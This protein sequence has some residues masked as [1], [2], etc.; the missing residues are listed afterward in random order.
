MKSKT[1]TAAAPSLGID[2]PSGG[3]GAASVMRRFVPTP[4]AILLA[5]VLALVAALSAAS[6][7][8]FAQSPPAA[9]IS[10]DLRGEWVGAGSVSL[11]WGAVE[12]ATSYGIRFWD[13]DASGWLELSA[14]GDAD[15][16]SLTFNGANAAVSG[17]PTHYRN[18]FFSVRAR[19]AGS[20]PSRPPP[21]PSRTAGSARRSRAARRSLPVL[22][23]TAVRT[24]SSSKP[25][26]AATSMSRLRSAGALSGPDAALAWA[27]ARWGRE[28]PPPFLPVCLVAVRWALGASA[29]WSP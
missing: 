5:V 29:G 25:C 16:I 12:G 7:P 6:G 4:R 11:G 15:G 18:Y 17:L 3:H 1:T 9:P 23:L 10:D 22:F 21:S 27:G 13:G 19:N 20:S 28:A 14:G 24:P 2:T 8:V 26:S